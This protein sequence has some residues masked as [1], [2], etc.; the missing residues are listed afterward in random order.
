M[1][2]DHAPQQLQKQLT[3][4]PIVIAPQEAAI[5]EEAPPPGRVFTES[6]P[7]KTKVVGIA[8]MGRDGPFVTVL[9]D[10][11]FNYEEVYAA[12]REA[13]GFTE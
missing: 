9:L 12:I 10:R 13:L 5:A 3:A 11:E 2:K 7:A 6:S 4:E 8:Q 1:T